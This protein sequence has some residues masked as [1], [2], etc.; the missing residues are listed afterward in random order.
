MGPYVVSEGPMVATVAPECPSWCLSWG[1]MGWRAAHLSKALPVDRGA[2]FEESDLGTQ[3][4][5]QFPVTSA[6]GGPGVLWAWT[7]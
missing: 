1:L 6:A 4:L 7:P 3:L 5:Y 2:F